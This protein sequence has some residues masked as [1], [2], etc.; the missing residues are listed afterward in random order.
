M[1]NKL[2][3]CTGTHTYTHL[4]LR[5]GCGSSHKDQI[6][7]W[8]MCTN[9]YINIFICV[10][11]YNSQSCQELYMGRPLFLLQN[12]SEVSRWSLILKF[13]VGLGPQIFWHTNIEGQNG[14]ITNSWVSLVFLAS[15]LFRKTTNQIKPKTK[16]PWT[17]LSGTL[18]L[19]VVYILLFPHENQMS[20]C[21][22]F[23]TTKSQLGTLNQ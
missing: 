17:Q 21:I 15:Q 11:K 10:H 9:R 8:R 13:N 2:G 14:R 5:E 20:H 6:G 18:S 22:L 7:R 4:L 1:I 12:P 23:N 19:H 16:I 3:V